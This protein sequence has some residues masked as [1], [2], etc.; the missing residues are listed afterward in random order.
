MSANHAEIDPEQCKGCRLCVDVC[1]RGCMVIGSDIN[2]SGY[3]FAKFEQKDC[4]ACGFCYY[5][6]PEPGAIKVFKRK[7]EAK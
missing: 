4:T 2:H 6:C 5:T 7:R 3:Q 1:P